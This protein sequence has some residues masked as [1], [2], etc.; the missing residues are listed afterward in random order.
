[1]AKGNDGSAARRRTMKKL[2]V[3]SAVSLIV[4]CLVV[5]Y[6]EDKGGTKA[7][8]GEP[9]HHRRRH[10]GHH[11]TVSKYINGNDEKGKDKND[12]DDKDGQTL[13][14]KY[15]RELIQELGQSGSK[16]DLD[17]IL[18]GSLNLVDL[19]SNY[20]LRPSQD[21]SYEGVIGKF[22]RLDFSLHKKDPSSYPM[23]RFMLQASPGCID[24]I[25]L[26]LHKVAYLARQ[27]DNEEAAAE[28][29]PKLLNLTAVAFHESRCGSTLVANSMIAM[30]PEKHRAYSESPP[31][32]SAVHM[33]GEYFEHCRKEQAA[34]ILKDTIYLMSRTDDPREERVFFKF[35]SITSKRIP[36]FQMAFPKVPWMYIYR[37]PVQVMM[38]HVKDE[39]S[40]KRAICTKSRRSPPKE[41]EAIAHRHG[42]KGAHDLEPSEYCAAHLAQLTEAAVHS[43]NGLAIPIAYDQLPGILWEAVLPNIFGRPLEPFEITNLQEISKSYSKQGKGRPKKGEFKGDSAEKEKMAS[44]EVR[45][46]A[47][48]FL[49]ES[50]DQLAAFDSNFLE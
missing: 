22:C 50:F 49:K 48:E 8:M 23:F 42:R 20:K 11:E 14:E 46:A 32:I 37:D 1:M 40:L 41:I 29:G 35:Q 17:K 24:P 47:K 33:C 4:V 12:D 36:I 44:T 2:F 10:P 26:D 45:E 15:R 5:F 28:G 13:S 38:S 7:S 6:T 31:P 43:L 18:N 3:A 21:G 30:D 16:T 27:R 25:A 34:S 9:H 19:S 39:P